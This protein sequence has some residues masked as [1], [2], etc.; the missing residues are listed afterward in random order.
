M[1]KINKEEIFPVVNSEGQTIGSATRK[2]CHT[3]PTLLHPTVHIHFINSQGQL[4]LQ[5][6]PMHKDM[7]PGKWD[8]AVG[9]HVSFGDTME[10]SVY[11]ET[12]EEIGVTE[13]SP[14]FIMKYVWTSSQE[15]E[16]MHT[17]IALYNGEFKIDRT[18]LD[19]ARF[20]NIE[21]IE[22]NLG[23]SIFTPNFEQEFEMLKEKKVFTQN[24][25]KTK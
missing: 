9:G 16:L 6:R 24:R 2:E 13:F 14:Q 18:E 15:S 21:E 11:R 1:L 25:M 20:W 7:Q 19:D 23:R 3:N 8:T 5:K 12:Q 10:N 22:K 4:F 17:H